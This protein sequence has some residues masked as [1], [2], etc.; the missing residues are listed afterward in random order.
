MA[1]R[2]YDQLV[3]MLATAKRGIWN[4]RGSFG[5]AD[6]GT[7]TYPHT[8]LLSAQGNPGAFTVGTPGLNGRYIDG[9]T[10]PGVIPYTNATAGKQKYICGIQRHVAG[11]ATYWLADLIWIN[12]GIVVTTTGLQSFTPGAM[13]N[14]DMNGAALGHGVEAGL[15]VTSTLGAHGTITNAQYDYTNQAGV[16]R[17]S[18]PIGRQWSQSMDAGHLLT[19]NLYPGDTGVRSI[20]GIRLGT[21]LISGSVSAVLFRRVAPGFSAPGLSENHIASWAELGLPKLYDNTAMFLIHV[22]VD[23]T[24][25]FHAASLLVVMGES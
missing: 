8:H 7:S 14:R 2:N 3:S 11:W 10:E 20:D 13:Q 18:V 6:P 12:S 22:P 21:S 16:Q 23:V 17:T 25:E 15:L 4:K 24:A 19:F 9:T 1:V 5:F